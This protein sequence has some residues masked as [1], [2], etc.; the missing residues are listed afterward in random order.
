VAVSATPTGATTLEALLDRWQH[1]KQQEIL[2][3]T[4]GSGVDVLVATKAGEAI[5]KGDHDGRH[6][7]FPD[8]PVEP[9]RQVLAEAYPIRVG[10]AATREAN[11][12]HEERQALSVMPG[13]DIDVDNS[14]RRITQHIALQGV[15]LDGDPTDRTCRAEKLAHVAHPWFLL[16][17]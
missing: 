10:E 3:G 4:H 12:I 7:P 1:F 8:Q 13:R 16:T 11:K 2:P 6:A 9:L 5:R 15:A 17:L 14:R